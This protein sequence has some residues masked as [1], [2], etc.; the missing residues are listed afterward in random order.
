MCFLIEIYHELI[1]VYGE[2]LLSDSD[3]GKYIE[4]LTL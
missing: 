2:G 1:A 3:V 4:W